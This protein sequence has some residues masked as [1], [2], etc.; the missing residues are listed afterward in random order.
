VSLPSQGFVGELS[1]AGKV[2][3]TAVLVGDDLA[4][5]AWHCVAANPDGPMLIR[6]RGQRT[7]ACWPPARL[8]TST[9]TSPCSSSRRPKECCPLP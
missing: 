2:L 6:F 4:I 3:G 1:S 7:Q 9:S 5:T 8:T